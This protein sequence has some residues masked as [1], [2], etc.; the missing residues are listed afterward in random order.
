MYQAFVGE[1]ELDRERE[2]ERERG[3]ERRKIKANCISNMD[4]SIGI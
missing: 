4:M 2:R 1:R 3:R